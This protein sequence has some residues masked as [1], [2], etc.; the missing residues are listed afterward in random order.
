[1]QGESYFD[2]RARLGSTIYALRDLAREAGLEESRQALAANLVSGLREPFLFVVAGEV[3]AGKSTFLNALFGAEI[4]VTGVLPTTG[5]IHWFKYDRAERTEALSAEFETHYR[6][7][8]FLRDFQIVDTPGVNS[9]AP[10]HE[11][12]AD[13]FVP[14]ADMVIFVFAVTNPWSDA[15]WKFLE[16]VRDTW[17]KR[18]VFVLQQC[19]LREPEEVGAVVEHMRVTAVARL[20]REVPIFPVSAK[21]AFAAK[22]SPL[23][24]EAL[25][26]AS[27]F[28]PLEV[29][30]MRTVS[31][32]PA[33]SSRLLAAVRAGRSVLRE[34]AERMAAADAA[35]D[36][37]RDCLG[38]LEGEAAAAVARTGGWRRAAAERF[39]TRYAALAEACRARVAARDSAAAAKLHQDLEEGGGE[40]AASAA[41]MMQDDLAELAKR[42]TARLPEERGGA[43]PEAVPLPEVSAAEID[44]RFRKV[45]E[46]VALEVDLGGIMDAG[47]SRRRMTDGAGLLL[48]L[49]GAGVMVCAYLMP[50]RVPAPAGILGGLAVALGLA[51]LMVARRIGSRT[52][53]AAVDGALRR[54]GP[55]FV[56]GC[57]DVLDAAAQDAF[58][59]YGHRFGPLVA[60]IEARRIGYLPIVEKVRGYQEAFDE[61]ERALDG[62]S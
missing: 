38:V 53:R 21:L 32:T 37:D 2:L 41:A 26:A 56:H 1:M 9:I 3:N 8:P 13:R 18:V 11:A 28:P 17:L 33:R 5:R 29:A 61:F 45:G 14:R 43:A 27:G 42:I 47:K 10:E 6:T 23:H 35:L 7:N 25:L 20:G 22:T 57:R 39:E 4:C 54:G 50:E 31:G 51:F 24:D 12:I 30:L 55:R 48:A 46:A 60:A 16:R 49:A 15:A 44:E 19:D 58:A 34:V 62:S 59:A 52:T 40:F 36:D